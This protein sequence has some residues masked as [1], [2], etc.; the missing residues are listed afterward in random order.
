MVSTRS[1]VESVDVP[2][3][4]NARGGV[5]V[6]MIGWTLARSTERIDPS[7]DANLEAGAVSEMHGI[8]RF[9]FHEAKL[10]DSE[11][12]IE[13][14]AHLGEL[15]EAIVATGSVAGDL[16][17]SRVHSSERRWRTARSVSSRSTSRRKHRPAATRH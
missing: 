1:A 12:L 15:M 13:H 2:P 16:L 9:R 6:A 4:T 3:S 14:A 5:A 10:R 11:A 17:A 8:A 7:R